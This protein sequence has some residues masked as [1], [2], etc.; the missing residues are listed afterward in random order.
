MKINR[1]G[2]AKILTPKEIQQLFNEGFQSVR[3]RAL[4]GVC[5]YTACR[6]NEACTLNTLDVYDKRMRVRDEVI[7][8]RHNTKGKLAARAVPVIEELRS[9]LVKYQPNS[10]DGFL[11]PGRHGRG[12]INSESASRILHETCEMIGFEGVSTH[13]F[14]RT[15][16][17]QMSNSGIPLR[18]IQEISGH[19][20]LE[21]L[22]KYLEVRPEQV[23]GAM[24]SL[25]MLGHVGDGYIRK[26]CFVD[27]NPMPDTETVSR[28]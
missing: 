8:R 6:I 24:S 10:R 28:D 1:H 11:F 22:Q 2:K 25:S 18:I 27:V 9:L 23:K 26:S 14:R 21:E 20:N 5:L 12:H 17:T 15:A 13:S 3:D 16:L 7:F 19:R 4:F